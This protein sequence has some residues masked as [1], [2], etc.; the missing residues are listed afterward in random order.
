MFT[1]TCKGLFIAWIFCP[2]NFIDRDTVS[3]NIILYLYYDES[4]TSQYEKILQ[5]H[6]VNTRKY[7]L[8]EVN[9]NYCIV[10]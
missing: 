2:V 5:A 9:E 3:T 7:C 4:S 10:T 8:V 6:G 1:I